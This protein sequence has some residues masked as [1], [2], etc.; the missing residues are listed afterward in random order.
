MYI[1]ELHYQVS[2]LLYNNLQIF[3]YRRHLQCFQEPKQ[4]KPPDKMSLLTLL[5]TQPRLIKT[6]QHFAT[7]TNYY[8]LLQHVLLAEERCIRQ[9]R[10]ASMV[11]FGDAQGTGQKL[12]IRIGSCFFH[13]HLTLMELV[14]YASHYFVNGISPKA[15]LDAEK[16]H[17]QIVPN[18][19]CLKHWFR[20]LR[21]KVSEKVRAFYYDVPLGISN[22]ADGYPCVECDKSLFTHFHDP[23]KSKSQRQ[24]WVWGAYDHATKDIRLYVVDGDRSKANLQS[25]I[26][27]NVATIPENKTFLITNGW[28]GYSTSSPQALDYIHIKVK[29]T[30]SFNVGEFNA[31]HIEGIWGEFKGCPFNKIGFTGG[32][33]E[34]F[35]IWVDYV[36]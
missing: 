7:K 33:I 12:A 32:T 21:T 2:F 24:V 28:K 4:L 23:S 17:N 1:L 31:N 6:H 19:K 11:I 16:A 27:N 9:K 35:H 30:K 34:D 22:C 25:L 18:L 20:T 8:M 14:G 3:M 13:L 26:L 10:K 36:S 5:W 15:T 29:H